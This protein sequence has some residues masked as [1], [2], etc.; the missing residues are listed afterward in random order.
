MKSRNI[1]IAAACTCLLSACDDPT[2]GAGNGRTYG[3][4]TAIGAGSVRTYLTMQD[5]QPTELGV[6]LSEAAL[7]G[8][9][10][11]PIMLNLPFPSQAAATQYTFMMFDWNP[12]G[13]EPLGIYGHPHFD[14]HFYLMPEREVAAIAG[15]P[16][17][18]TPE[19]SLVPPGYIAPGNISVPGMGVHWIAANAPELQGHLFDKTM[20]YGFTRGRLIFIEPM[21]TTAFL[22]TKPNF[23]ASIA[24]P[25]RVEAHGLYPSRYSV[26][27]DAENREYRISIHGFVQR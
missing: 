13:H 14:F 2:G 18:I 10:S 8:L 19:A 26:K 6:A 11:S 15:G 22:Q 25:R 5:G 12:T 21:I 24:Q 1:L 20:I 23:E 27:Y 7:T 4:A 9:P 16:D 3:P 17:P